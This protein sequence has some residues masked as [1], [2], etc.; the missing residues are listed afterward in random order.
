MAWAAAAA[1]GS[2][3][4][5]A[6]ATAQAPLR[7][8]GPGETV[9]GALKGD[10]PRTPDEP[11]PYD[12]YALNASGSESVT[13]KLSASAFTPKF[14]VGRGASCLGASYQ[15]VVTGPA[16]GQPASVTF[17]PAPGRY[18][19]MVQSPDGKLGAY[20]L[21]AD[22][23]APMQVA[24]AGGVSRRQ[25]M[26]SQISKRRAEVAA[27]EARRQE[28]ARRAAEREAARQE[29]LA[30]IEAENAAAAAEEEDDEPP[31]PPINLLGVFANSFNNAM[32]ENAAEKARQQAFLNDLAWQQ[33]QAQR[34]RE[35]RAELARR[36]A[37]ERARQARQLAAAN[38]AQRQA[39]AQ[40][41]A[42][43]QQQQLAEQNRQLEQQRQQQQHAAQQRQQQLAQQQQRPPTATPQSRPAPSASA[44]STNE[45]PARC[46]AQPTVSRGNLC[47]DAMVANTI[48]GC[49]QPVDIRMCLKKEAGGW[50][51]GTRWGVQPQASASYPVCGATSEIFWSAR[52]SNG[53]GPLANPQ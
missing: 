20:T 18:M 39:A 31:R 44:A 25:I 27:E 19:V 11:E 49:A 28:E 32:A 12:C 15:Y 8:I 45:D 4:A 37:D 16:N 17:K 35:E 10:A 29:E 21:T 52:S 22:G 48:N 47:K 40:E 7:T 34:A 6:G 46:V 36:Q 3:L 30:R 14:S 23:S 42:R 13:I 50:D 51:C 38:E 41:L 26:E 9:T 43:R 33:R 24:D 5:C 2:L 1:A 53:G